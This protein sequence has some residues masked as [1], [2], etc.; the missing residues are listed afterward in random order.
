MW[1]RQ[2]ERFG[3]VAVRLYGRGNSIDG[4]AAQLLDELTGDD[5]ALVGASMGGYTALA[6]DAAGAGASRGDRP[7]GLQGRAGQARAPRGARRR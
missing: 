7:R 2:V 3:G 4:W 6:I 5:L 1:D